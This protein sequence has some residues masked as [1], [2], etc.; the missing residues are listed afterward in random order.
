MDDLVQW[1][2]EQL[3]ADAA[4]IPM[5]AWHEPWCLNSYVVDG[6]CFY[7]G[8]DEDPGNVTYQEQSPRALREVDAKRGILARYEF[9]CREAAALDIDE[10]ERETRVQ[11]A[12]AFESCVVLLAAVY[13]D[14][15][16][17]LKS[18][19]P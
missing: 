10:E 7:C 8:A 15:P 16:G 9:A 12:A 2:G 11:V 3:D 13:A 19:R 1:L 17:Y 4:P 14:R 18:W 5:P 6:V